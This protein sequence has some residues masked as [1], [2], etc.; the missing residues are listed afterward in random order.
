MIPKTTI[1]PFLFYS[2]V[3]QPK[4]W[5][6]W[7]LSLLKCSKSRVSSILL[8]FLFCSTAISSILSASVFF[9]RTVLETL[10]GVWF[11]VF[12]LQSNFSELVKVY[13]NVSNCKTKPNIQLNNNIKIINR[14]TLFIVKSNWDI[15]NIST[16]EFKIHFAQVHLVDLSTKHSKKFV[17]VY[18]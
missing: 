7:L 11:L 2:L 15:Y 8:K 12:I 4:G 10:E 17:N 18:R 1:A 5:I 13:S 9:K 16:M 3:C 6:L 14:I